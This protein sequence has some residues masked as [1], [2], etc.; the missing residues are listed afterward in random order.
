MVLLIQP[1]LGAVGDQLVSDTTTEE[2]FFV[3]G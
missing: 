3:E 2:M 1:H